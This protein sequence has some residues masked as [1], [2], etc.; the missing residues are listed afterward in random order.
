MFPYYT[1]WKHQKPFGFFVVFKGYEIGVSARN[2]LINL[3]MHNVIKWLKHPLKI[4]RYEHS[5]IFIVCL[6]ILQHY[7][8]K[9]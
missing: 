4:L 8:S 6:A 5:K 1:P 2:K 7:A 9:G 3:L